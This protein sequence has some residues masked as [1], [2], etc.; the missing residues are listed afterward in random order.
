MSVALTPYPTPSLF[1]FLLTSHDLIDW[2]T[3]KKAVW[4]T[5]NE[6]LIKL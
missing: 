4:E 1:F 2:N 5:D 6:G 3:R